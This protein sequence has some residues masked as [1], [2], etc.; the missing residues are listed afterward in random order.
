MNKSETIIL[1]WILLT[2]LVMGPGGKAGEV[3]DK[4]LRDESL[5]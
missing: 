5:S 3:L 2:E 4:S 1:S